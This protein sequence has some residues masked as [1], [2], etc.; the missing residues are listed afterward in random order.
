MKK[1]KVIHT[2]NR[3]NTVEETL[4][5]LGITKKDFLKVVREIKSLEKYEPFPIR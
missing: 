1:R 3:P 4:K 5:I 2:I